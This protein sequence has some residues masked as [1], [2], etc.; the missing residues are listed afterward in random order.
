MYNR[1][2]WNKKFIRKKLFEL[3]FT[4]KINTVQMTSYV[5]RSV[6]LHIYHHSSEHSLTIIIQS[7]FFSAFNSISHRNS[8]FGTFVAVHFVVESSRKKR[9]SKSAC[10]ESLHLAYVF[11]SFLFVCQWQFFWF[12]NNEMSIENEWKWH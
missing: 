11:L 6:A 2:R 7:F 4:L 1:T 12:E 10:R 3:L 9:E 8:I 5:W